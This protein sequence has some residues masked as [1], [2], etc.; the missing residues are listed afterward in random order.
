MSKVEQTAPL[1]T[2]A[3]LSSLDKKRP[4]L[5]MI[6]LFFQ[7][8]SLLSNVM[9]LPASK[10]ANTLLSF[11]AAN[12][13]NLVFALLLTGATLNFLFYFVKHKFFFW[14]AALLFLISIGLSFLCVAF[15]LNETDFAMYRWVFGTSAF[16]SLVMLCFTFYVAIRDIF[17]ENLTIGSALL[18]AAN[19][20]LLIGSGFAFI[21]AFLS[22]LMPGAMIP[23][24]EMEELFNYSVINSTY[25]LAG[26][27]LPGTVNEPAFKNVMMFESIFAHL[28]AVFIVGR[29]LIKG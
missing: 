27:D 16:I 24:S 6:L 18:G 26:M 9:I 20:Y 12:L 29:L 2:P 7:V 3:P 8:L 15:Q 28:F 13:L 11:E 10:E 4:A 17:G 19:I 14:L 5:Y 25:I 22:I 23:I 1:L 21:Y